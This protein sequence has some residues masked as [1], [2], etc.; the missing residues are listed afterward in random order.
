[1]GHYFRVMLHESLRDGQVQSWAV[2]A[3]LDVF[4]LFELGVGPE[5]MMEIFFCLG[6]FWEDAGLCFAAGAHFF[7]SQVVLEQ[8]SV[9]SNF[10]AQA[11]REARAGAH[12]AHAISEPGSGSDVFSMAARAT[13]LPDGRFQIRASKTYV[14]GAAEA[15][16]MLLY[17][18]T[19]P[20]KGPLGGLSSFVLKRGEWEI[21]S[22][23]QKMGL[24]SCSL[25]S[26]EVD[27]VFESERLVGETPGGGY[28]QFMRAMDWERVGLSAIH[29]GTMRKVLRRTAKYTQERQ[30]GGIPNSSHQAVAFQLAEMAVA[31]ETSQL[32]VQHAASMLEKSTK[33]RSQSAAM[34]KLHVSEAL[35]DVCRKSIQ[36]HGGAGYVE[37]VGPARWM[38]DA[39]ASTIYSGTS[40]MQRKII[41]SYL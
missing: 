1:M 34:C 22:N 31:A 8:T 3:E 7:G 14:S 20:E 36:L 4:R 18:M 26:I 28:R 24:N 13:C 17:A 35:V 29:A 21:T 25:C 11:L 30:Q 12:F 15:D 27:G 2:L 9:L 37:G 40:E 39:L 16:W 19:D 33:H 23:L 6:G 38:R 10:N 41:S 32:M 5:E